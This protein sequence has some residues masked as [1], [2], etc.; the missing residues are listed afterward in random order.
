M[1]QSPSLEAFSRSAGQESRLIIRNVKVLLSGPK[2]SVTGLYPEPVQPSLKSQ[3][4]FVYDP[5]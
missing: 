4:P 5:F 3:T 2:Q 1:K